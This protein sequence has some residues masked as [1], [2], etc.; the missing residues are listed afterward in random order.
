MGVCARMHPRMVIFVFGGRP[1]EEPS[2]KIKE[3]VLRKHYLAL[4]V[5]SGQ[6]ET[7]RNP[8]CFFSIQFLLIFN[9]IKACI[10]L[11]FVQC[12]NFDLFRASHVPAHCLDIQKQ[13]LEKGEQKTING[14]NA[15]V[16][17]PLESGFVC[18]VGQPCHL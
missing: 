17:L 3:S 6:P 4:Q 9:N 18:V 1:E 16:I 13:A 11:I 10:V 7:E 8:S 14:N 2:C 12:V 5:T 15:L